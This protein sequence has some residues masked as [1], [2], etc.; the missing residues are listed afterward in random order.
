M[1]LSF[2][3]GPGAEQ[4]KGFVVEGPGFGSQ[5]GELNAGVSDDVESVV[6]QGEL[7]DDGV[8]VALGAACRASDF[9]AGELVDPLSMEARRDH[10]G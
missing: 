3:I 4:L 1:R 10:D 6:V 7:A 5:D 8:V 9:V 2:G